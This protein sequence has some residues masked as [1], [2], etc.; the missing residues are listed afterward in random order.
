MTPRAAQAAPGLV[1]IEKLQTSPDNP[2]VRFEREGLDELT[3]SIREHGVLQPLLVR[4]LYNA[5]EE[6]SGSYEVICGHRRLAA[7]T[8]AGLMHVPVVVRFAADDE[9]RQLQ[10][11]ENLQRADLHPM[12]EAEAFERLSRDH[13]LPAEEIAAKVGRS[14]SHVYQRMKLTAL[15]PEARKAF[16]EGALTP[17]VA[18]L[19]ARVPSALQPEVLERLAR[20]EDITTG[21]AREIVQGEFMLELKGAPF[22]AADACLLDG[23]PACG[24]CPKRT[25]SSPLLFDDVEKGDICTDPGCFRAKSDATWQVTKAKSEAKGTEC[26]DDSAG[27]HSNW[28]GDTVKSEQYV[29]PSHGEWIEGTHRTWRSLV[30]KGQEPPSTL[31]RLKGGKTVKVW[32]RASALKA[33]RAAGTLKR[34]KKADGASTAAAKRKAAINERV[35]V[36]I[37]QSA[38]GILRAQL[39]NEPTKPHKLAAALICETKIHLSWL[40]WA[41]PVAGLESAG[42]LHKTAAKL[43]ILEIAM[44]AFAE[45]V[46][47]ADEHELAKLMRLDHAK[48]SREADEALKREETKAAAP[49]PAP[50]AANPK[51]ARRSKPKK[52]ARRRTRR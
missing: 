3:A 40:S 24:A 27:K 35:A 31:L 51:P 23:V 42:D 19:V 15:G 43:S 5:N 39:G 21:R 44:L 17:A 11:I 52:G 14:P 49:A 4:P 29:E 34:E 20:H 1:P 36:R 7:A 41:W 6:P 30:P 2:R 47:N 13:G 28:N 25:G 8:T 32:D 33:A 37:K 26:L 50:A 22:N 45:A 10:L 38:L 18:L 12:D 9:V 48:L 46:Q 16:L